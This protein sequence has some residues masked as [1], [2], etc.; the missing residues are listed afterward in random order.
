MIRWIKDLAIITIGLYCLIA[1]IAFVMEHVHM[2]I[3]IGVVMVLA[4][5]AALTDERNNEREYARGMGRD[6][7]APKE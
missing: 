6:P 4:A 5:L 2:F 3:A 1:I 7:D